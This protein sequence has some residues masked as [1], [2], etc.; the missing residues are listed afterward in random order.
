M[1]IFI[2]IYYITNL[3][4]HIKL[5]NLQLTM[6]MKSF[7]KK[8]TFDCFNPY[9]D[10]LSISKLLVSNGIFTYGILLYIMLTDSYILTC[11]LA[12]MWDYYHYLQ[13]YHTQDWNSNN[14]FTFILFFQI[15]FNICLRKNKFRLRW[16]LKKNINNYFN[17]S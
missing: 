6:D 14:S 12:N 13:V 3:S 1:K 10:L 11:T 16:L 7:F 17:Y 2:L 5:L 15:F 8:N 4:F 9:F